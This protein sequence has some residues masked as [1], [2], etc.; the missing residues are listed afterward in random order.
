MGRCRTS[1][2][3]RGTNSLRTLQHRLR[4]WTVCGSWSRWFGL[5]SLGHC[6]FREIWAPLRHIID[7]PALV[8]ILE[9]SKAAVR[10]ADYAAQGLCDLSGLRIVMQQDGAVVFA[11]GAATNGEVPGHGLF[12]RSMSCSIYQGH[13][14]GTAVRSGHSQHGLS[15]EH[16]LLFLL[17]AESQS[18]WHITFLSTMCSWSHSTDLQN[19][20]DTGIM[21]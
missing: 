18:S 10:L 6:L 9:F 2:R 16:C 3:H 14:F 19:V 12:S 11:L 8:T 20:L 21:L 15:L 7:D 5:G 1:S 4:L 13:S 17:F